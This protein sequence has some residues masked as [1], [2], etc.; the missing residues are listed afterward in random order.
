MADDIV[1]VTEINMAD[2]AIELEGPE[3][4]DQPVVYYF[5]G[6]K[7]EFVDKGEDS[8]LYNPE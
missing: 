6:G 3:F 7:R 4:Y 5:G 1:E 8:A 2:L